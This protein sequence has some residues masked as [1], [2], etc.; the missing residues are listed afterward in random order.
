MDVHA[1]IIVRVSHILN[2]QLR[3]D[4]LLDKGVKVLSGNVEGNAI[5]SVANKYGRTPIENALVHSG[6]GEAE[7]IY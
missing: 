4:Q 7:L 6:L 1:D 2:F 5:V 3:V